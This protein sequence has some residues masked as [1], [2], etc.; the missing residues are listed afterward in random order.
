[1]FKASY[2]W[3]YESVL[4]RRLVFPSENRFPQWVLLIVTTRDDASVPAEEMLNVPIYERLLFIVV[5]SSSNNG[6]H[7]ISVRI[8]IYNL[9]ELNTGADDR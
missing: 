8:R 3:R 7:K 4:K 6:T 2:K 1:M 9:S 5:I